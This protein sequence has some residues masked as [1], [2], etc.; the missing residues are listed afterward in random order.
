[1][2]AGV[3]D[4]QLTT[5]FLLTSNLGSLYILATVVDLDDHMAVPF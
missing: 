2:N 5:L 4:Q 1:M 3:Q